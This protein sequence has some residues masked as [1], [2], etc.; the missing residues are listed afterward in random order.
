M[1]AQ[2]KTISVQAAARV[3]LLEH[4]VCVCFYR[5]V[6]TES[7][8]KKRI[9]V[10]FKLHENKARLKNTTFDYLNGIVLKYG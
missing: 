9:N 4:C 3:E 10:I 2:I 7:K 1:F 6:S 5:K 8:L